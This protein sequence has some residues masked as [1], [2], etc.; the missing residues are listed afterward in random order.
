MEGLFI[1]WNDKKNKLW[2]HSLIKEKN[3]IVG[4]LLWYKRDKIL[5][6]ETPFYSS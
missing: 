5:F 3:V 2:G 1:W 4:S 6:Y